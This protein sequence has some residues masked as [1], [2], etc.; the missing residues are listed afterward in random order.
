[1][2]HTEQPGADPDSK[3]EES[4]ISSSDPVSEARLWLGPSRQL[5]SAP[6]RPG[7]EPAAHASAPQ[8]GTPT[9]PAVLEKAPRL[10]TSTPCGLDGHCFSTLSGLCDQSH[11]ISSLLSCLIWH[12]GDFR[13]LSN[14]NTYSKGQSPFLA[15]SDPFSVWILSGLKLSSCRPRPERVTVKGPVAA[16][17]SQPPAWRQPTSRTSTGRGRKRKNELATACYPSL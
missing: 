2:P 8:P 15:S 4:P 17:C 5:H 7:M 13:E 14:H 1:M 6:W 9:R 3:R 12:F 16:P 10:N 11:T